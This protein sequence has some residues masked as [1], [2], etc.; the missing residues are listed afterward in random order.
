[1]LMVVPEEQ[2]EMTKVLTQ[3]LVQEDILQLE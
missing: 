2:V 1:M 3:V